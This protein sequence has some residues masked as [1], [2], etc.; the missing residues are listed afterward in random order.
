MRESATGVRRP[1]S[2]V[3]SSSDP[4]ALDPTG[5]RLYAQFDE[6]RAAGP[7][8]RVRLLDGVVAW[9][10]SRG[11]EAKYLLAHPD[12]AKDARTAWPGYV[13]YAIPWLFPW[14]D[15]RSMFTSDGADHRR[16]RGMVAKAF[17][18]RRV[19]ALRPAIS[20][21]VGRLLGELA[22]E[23]PDAVIDLRARYSYRLPTEVICDLLGVP[24]SDRARLLR[25]ADDMLNTSF[26]REQS[27]EVKHGFQTVLGELIEVKRA[28]PGND[29]ISLLLEAHTGTEPSLTR[30][31]LIST[32]ILITGAGS[33]T[34]IAL[35][36][37]AVAMLLTH[38]AQ[39]AAVTADPARWGDVIDETLRQHPPIAHL[40]MRFATADIPL[41]EVTI[42][43]GDPIV[44][45]F[46]A[47]GRDPGANADPDDFALDREDRDHL[48]F[49]YGMHYCLG[50][51]LA[52][53]QAE[54]ALSAL[55][56]TFPGLRLACEPAE[57]R[58]QTSFITNDLRALPVLLRPARA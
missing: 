11:A 3:R 58:R 14:V 53:V 45:A 2:A 47:H 30:E 9:S 48:A 12:V 1:D 6:L 21:I 13:P 37:H 22:A 35:I 46:G 7:A 40:P 42:P 38:P 51:P 20:S 49:G 8:V 29:M 54:I 56:T 26:T 17:T 39:R 43:A 16:L 4:V 32:M 57:L 31:E 24:D 36:D 44:I 19:A 15:V 34:I 52:R 33:E 25:L 10:V 27:A 18:P 50:A 23:P 55:F 41:G 5:R 28:R